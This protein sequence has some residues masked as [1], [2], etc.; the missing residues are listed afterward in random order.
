AQRK[1]GK[2]IKELATLN[3]CSFGVIHKIL[4]E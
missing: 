3:N 2:T 4:H 1:E